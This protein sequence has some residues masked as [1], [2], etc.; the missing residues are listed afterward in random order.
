[1]QSRSCIYALG[2]VLQERKT[3]LVCLG[4]AALGLDKGR[5]SPADVR[6][7]VDVYTMGR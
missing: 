1:M 6:E 3:E 7:T 4:E 2:T 5:M